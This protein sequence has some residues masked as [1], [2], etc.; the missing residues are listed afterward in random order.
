MNDAKVVFSA[1]ANNIDLTF[2]TTNNNWTNVKMGGIFSNW[3]GRNIYKKSLNDP[4]LEDKVV[5]ERRVMLGFNY[6][7]LMG[8]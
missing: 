4:H 6:N 5:F 3:V 1:M 7:T 2:L 8:T